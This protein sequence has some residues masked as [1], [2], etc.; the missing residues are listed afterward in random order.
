[1][2]YP[3]RREHWSWS[4]RLELV[5]RGTRD[6]EPLVDAGVDGSGSLVLTLGNVELASVGAVGRVRD[7]GVGPAIVSDIS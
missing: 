3:I 2:H 6:V 1:M 4:P 5:G 7:G